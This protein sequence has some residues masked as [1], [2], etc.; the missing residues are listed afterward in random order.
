[1]GVGLLHVCSA[2]A[3]AITPCFYAQLLIY[4]QVHIV[5]CCPK[6]FN[7]EPNA[8]VK[9]KQRRKPIHKKSKLSE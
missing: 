5:L 9:E 7:K 4:A 1:M 3:S 8:V 2:L 6:H